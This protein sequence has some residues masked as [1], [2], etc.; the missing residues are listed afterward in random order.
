L[1]KS[2]RGFASGDLSTATEIT[3]YDENGA[4]VTLGS[5][6]RVELIWIFIGP[7]T[8]GHTYTFFA[9]ADDDNTVDAGEQLIICKTS[10]LLPT[11]L[12][13]AP[14]QPVGQPGA[15]L[16]VLASG[17]Q[18]ASLSVGAIIRKVR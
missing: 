3:L 4:A 14:C 15:K 5:D 16:H 10:T 9:D 2:V 12:N 13:L 18:T 11:N 17:S 7:D 1:A 6:E 8:A